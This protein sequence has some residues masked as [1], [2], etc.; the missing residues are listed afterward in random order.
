MKNSKYKNVRRW[1]K[2]TK[3]KLV[4]AFGEHCCICDLRVDKYELYD[5]HHISKEDKKFELTH[6]IHSW[7]KIKEEAK[8]C[9]MLCSNCHRLHHAGYKEYIIPKEAKRFNE[10]LI[11]IDIKYTKINKCP[12][13]EKYKSVKLVYCSQKCVNINRRKVVRP[14]KKELVYLMKTFC[15]EEIADK[16]DISSNSVRKWAKKYNIVWEGSLYNKPPLF[17]E[18]DL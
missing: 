15:W 4:T 18:K 13:C 3:S 17:K 8:K 9:V 1:R 11:P 10:L 16:Y 7:K 2:N 12:T 6:N 14:S 5:F